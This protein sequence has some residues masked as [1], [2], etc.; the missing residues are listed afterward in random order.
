[1]GTAF[2]AMLTVLTQQTT[3][4]KN[5]YNEKMD[6]LK[7]HEDKQLN[8]DEKLKQSL[9]MQQSKLLSKLGW[10]TKRNIFIRWQQEKVKD[11]SVSE[12]PILEVLEI[13]YKPLGIEYQGRI[14]FQ[15]GKLVGQVN[16]LDKSYIVEKGSRLPGYTVEA[17]TKDHINLKDAKGS[18]KKI[19]YRKAAYTKELVATLREQT[20]GQT[21]DVS[22]NSQFLSYKVLDIDEESVLLSTQGQHLRLKKGM[23][24]K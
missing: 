13:G 4:N 23:V 15:E 2:L 6:R 21:Q 1:M 24:H 19:N 8:I 22:K 11:I 17:L 16:L 20:S 5:F 12:Q 9:D 3:G 7:A 10:R 14:V 18:C